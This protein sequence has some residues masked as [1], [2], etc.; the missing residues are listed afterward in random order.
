MTR[1]LYYEDTYRRRFDATVEA[2][3]QIDGRWHV[4]LDTTAFYP[5]GGGQPSDQG[6]IGG[7][8]VEYVYEKRGEVW[9]V[10]DSAFI[11]GQKVS[12]TI[13]WGRRFHFMQQHLGQHILSAIF[14]RDFGAATVS[15]HFGVE[16]STLDLDIPLTAAQAAEA[17]LMAND[18]VFKN[19]AIETLYPSPEEL[20]EMSEISRRKILETNAPIRMVTI[21]DI[22][23]TACC[24]THCRA[25]GEVG[26]IKLYRQES[27]KGGVRIGFACG[28]AAFTK[29]RQLYSDLS[30]MQRILSVAEGDIADRVEKLYEENIGLKRERQS[31]MNRIL[32]TEAD[33]MIVEALQVGDYKIVAE[34]MF[35]TTQEDLRGLFYQLTQRSGVVAILGGMVP[36]GAALM[37]GTHKAD[38]LVDVRDVFQQSLEFIDGR[39]GGSAVSCQGLGTDASRLG[40]VVEAASQVL[41]QELYA[42]QSERDQIGE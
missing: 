22:D 30:R 18:V 40:E 10:A 25:T 32:E 20:A 4:R 8:F 2:F 42:I 29:Y 28:G 39:G 14:Q 9:H 41:A 34:M 13:N 1:K 12:C 17:E 15:V 6:H 31:M 19:M 24:G 37:F 16:M 23:L 26:F 7:A 21:G 35:A 27:Y 33:K 36:D 11:V 5:E 38:K 3:E